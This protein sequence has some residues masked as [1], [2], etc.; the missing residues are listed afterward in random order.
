MKDG[1]KKKVKDKTDVKEEGR[2][3]GGERKRKRE[4]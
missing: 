3:S 2:K 1:G 4:R